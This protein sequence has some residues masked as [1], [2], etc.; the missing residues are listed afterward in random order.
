MPKAGPKNLI[1]DVA[2]INVGN[3][4]DAKL[5]S[6]VSAIILDR[7]TTAS[8]HLMGGGPGTR[9]TELLAPKNTVEKIDGLFLS[10]GS[11]FGLDAGGG[12]QAWLRENG[13][14]FSL[15]GQTIPLVPGA[16]IFDLVNGGDKDWDRFSP[17]QTL[18]Y[19]A[20]ARAKDTFEIGSHGAGKGAL[21]ASMLGGLGSASTKLENGITIG[22]LVVV[23]ALGSPL[24]GNS[25]HFWAA[26]FEEKDEFGAL[27]YPE[28]MPENASALN[29]KFRER[30]DAN[31]NTTI[32]VVAT[33]AAL[34]KAQCER[35]AIAAH[36]GIARAIWPAHTPL[37]G[38]LVFSLATGGSKIEPEMDDWIDLGAYAAS[39]LSRAIARGVYEAKA[40]ERSIFP[41][42]QDMG[43]K[44]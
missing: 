31:K 20:A 44:A 43:T 11:A 21:V 25:R 40:C 28:Q 42:Y 12:V 15:A 6:G 26:P 18:G 10:G 23:N 32:A 24:L 30:I 9:D 39:T 37:D 16:I 3:I 5:N 7:P 33:D 1:T 41:A 19:E 14:G 35:L 13:K 27:G 38:D 2:G 4:H 36:D 29:I 17:Y 22:A 8:V 34:S